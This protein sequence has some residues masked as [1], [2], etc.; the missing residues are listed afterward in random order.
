MSRFYE[1]LP[2]QDTKP[3]GA[4]DFYFAINATFRFLLKCLGEAGWVRYLQDLGREYYRPV[5]ELWRTGGS[6]AV[7]RYW[8]EFFAA[9]PGGDVEVAEAA[10]GV[11]EVRVRVCPAIQH[12]RKGGRAPVSQFCQHCW[13][14]GEARAQA[15]GMTMRLSRGNGSCVHYYHCN[16]SESRPPAQD[17]KAIREATV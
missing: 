9:E 10:N 15:A 4:A 11:V 7:A 13:H 1:T 8:R 14:L 3:Q 17:P 6:S 12:L 16:P 2:Y 5:N